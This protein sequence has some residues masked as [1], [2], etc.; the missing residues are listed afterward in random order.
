M[1]RRILSPSAFLPFILTI[2]ISAS[3]SRQQATAPILVH[4][5]AFDGVI[6]PADMKAFQKKF[7]EGV[8]YWTPS[9]SDVLLAERN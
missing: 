7:P 8:R 6:F 4:T 5:S 3:T 2:F 1:F 9:E